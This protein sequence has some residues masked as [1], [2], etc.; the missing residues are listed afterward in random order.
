MDKRY[1]LCVLVALVI[2]LVLSIL[3]ATSLCNFGGCT[4]AHQYRLFGL[5]FPAFGIMFFTTAGLLTV[6]VN[7]FPWTGSALDLLLAGAAGAEINM[8]LLQKY[9]IRAWCPICLGIAAVIYLVSASRLG[10]A[11]ISRKEEFHM[12]LKSIGKPLLLATTFLLG[13]TLTYYGIAKPEVAAAGQANLYLGKQ[14]SKLEVYVFS[15]WLCPMC[16]RVEGVIDTLYP[17]LAQ[18]ARLQF[19]DKI[20][21]PEAVNFV[22]Y[23]LSFATYEKSKYMSLRKALFAVAQKTKNPTYDD[24]KAAIAPLRVTYKQLSFMEVTQQMASDRKLA[25]QFKVTA[26]PTMVI[27][28]ARTNKVQNLVGSNEIT[29]DRVKKAMKEL[30]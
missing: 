26:T 11:F 6:L 2:G 24:I 30:E 29:P 3:S 12:T 18:K 9:V 5:S 1:R 28:N 27:R 8:I 17:V 13:F 23:H 25:E 16:V 22:P 14:D 4:E 7:R 20:I 10:T 19:V 21:H 15:D